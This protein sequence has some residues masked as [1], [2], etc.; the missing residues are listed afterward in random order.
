MH[1]SNTEGTC[2]ATWV[3]DVTEDE[4]DVIIKVEEDK[5]KSVISMISASSLQSSGENSSDEE[6]LLTG[7]VC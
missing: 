5:R 6:G 4:L 1:R 7:T 3:C 2:E